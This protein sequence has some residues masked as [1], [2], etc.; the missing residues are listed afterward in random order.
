MELKHWNGALFGNTDRLLIEPYGIET[1]KSLHS[2]QQT[3]TLLIEPYGIETGFSVP[4]SPL[5]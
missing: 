5:G 4:L 2:K 3:P 1:R